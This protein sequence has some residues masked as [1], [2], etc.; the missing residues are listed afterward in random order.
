MK[1]QGLCDLHTH[2]IYS[3]GT[4]T[5][6]ELVDMAAAVGLSAIALTDHNTTDGLPEFLSAARDRSIEAVAGVEFSVSYNGRELHLLGLF[7]DEKYFSEI[8]RLTAEMD[9]LKEKSNID[10]AHSLAKAGIVLDYEKIKKSTP[11]GRVNR[12]NFAS[13][14]VRLGYVKD[15]DEAFDVYLSPEAGH[16]K[17]P[18]R[19]ELFETI[20]LIRAMG[21]LPILA[22][23]FLQ[24]DEAELEDALPL[25]KAH[26]L[27]GMECYYSLYD[28]KTTEK[29]LEMVR[30]HGLLPSGGSDFHGEN[31]PK[32]KLGSGL[33][34][35]SIPHDLLL[36]LSASRF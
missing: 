11:N 23:P 3:D 33:G 17:E 9:A 16:Y 14:M 4:C 27:A 29:A 5:P 13:E 21:A 32:I 2:S 10:L 25:L 28:E 31:K 1:N 19:L 22:H 6:T 8:N 7:I 35:L 15:R 20:E 18:R 24:L 26:G 12:A 36:S 30:R 34:G